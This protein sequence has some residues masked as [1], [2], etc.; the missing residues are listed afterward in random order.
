MF[1]IA[2]VRLTEALEISSG[3]TGGQ[4]NCILI[5]SNM[6][7]NCVM[8]QLIHNSTSYLP[9]L[10]SLEHCQA[11]IIPSAQMKV[12]KELK[13]YII[14]HCGPDIIIISPGALFIQ[15]SVHFISLTGHLRSFLEG[16]QGP[17]RS[18]VQP[19]G[20]VPPKLL[21]MS[22]SQTPPKK[23]KNPRSTP[24]AP[25]KTHSS[26]RPWRINFRPITCN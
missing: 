26:V 6:S 11:F 20:F 17:V 16:F 18:Q 2:L 5:P 13:P 7:Q 24:H 12:H 14:L 15:E 21:S 4:S 8:K 19:L 3:V 10:Q 9:R 23:K 1:Y 25:A 22:Q